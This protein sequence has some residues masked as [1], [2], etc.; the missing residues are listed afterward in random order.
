LQIKLL[1]K[2]ARYYNKTIEEYHEFL[3]KYKNVKI[4]DMFKFKKQTSIR[5]SINKF[6]Q[7]IVG[8]IWEFI[9]NRINNN[10]NKDIIQFALDSGL[11]ERNSLG[12]GFMNLM[13][14]RDI[15]KQTAPL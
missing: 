5:L 12:F 7:I 6:E 3:A 11:G 15:Y 14:K 8:S 2:Y 10:N 13:T 4:F 9:F 1:S